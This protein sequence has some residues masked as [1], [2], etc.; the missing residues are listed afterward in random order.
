M[1]RSRTAAG[2]LLRLAQMQERGRA[3]TRRRT[4][5]S[6]PL[7]EYFRRRRE[8]RMEANATERRTNG[9][10]TSACR[11]PS[12]TATRRSDLISVNLTE[13]DPHRPECSP[14]LGTTKV[15]FDEGS[16]GNYGVASEV[17]PD[18]PR[19]ALGNAG[20]YWPRCVADYDGRMRMVGRIN[21]GEAFASP[22]CSVCSWPR[23]C[24]STP[25]RS[26]RSAAGAPPSA[27]DRPLGRV[28]T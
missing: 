15:A 4:P 24:C 6:R 12:K 27:N 17:D 26:R 3:D 9:R 20:R 18:V 21:R 2:P 22:R 23:P 14:P 25:T 19:Q 1:A 10:S 7:G 13:L 5:A 8:L 16:P 28:T 11:A